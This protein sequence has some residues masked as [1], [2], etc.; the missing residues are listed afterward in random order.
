MTLYWDDKYN[1]GH[2]K[3][4][5]EHHIFLNLIVEFESLAVQEASQD[6]LVRTLKEISK[7]AEFHFFSEENLM[8]DCNYPE[9]E[10]HKSLHRHLI[11]SLE[12][13]LFK[14]KAGTCSAGQVFDFL[15]QW[16]ALHTSNEDKKLVTFVVTQR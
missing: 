2:E 14:L 12:D 1:L 10:Q 3:V 9:L 15:F 4:D 13:Q 6:K 7:Y 11:A 8:T 5:A 16:F